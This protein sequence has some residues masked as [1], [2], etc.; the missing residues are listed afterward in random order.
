MNKTLR[1]ARCQIL[2]ACAPEVLRPSGS[3]GK[4]KA[5]IRTQTARDVM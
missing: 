3:I 2:E 5:G 4:I 1:T